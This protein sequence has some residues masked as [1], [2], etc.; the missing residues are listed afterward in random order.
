M[1]MDDIFEEV[2]ISGHKENSN[3][4]LLG[5]LL[6]KLASWG[7]TWS[8]IASGV[9]NLKGIGNVDTLLSQQAK[10]I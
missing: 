3:T 9:W 4:F 1:K 2:V 10:E 6:D 7:F 5:I 8:L